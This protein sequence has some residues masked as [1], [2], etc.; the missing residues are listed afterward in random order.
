VIRTF[1]AFD[2]TPGQK[3]ILS[4]AAVALKKASADVRWES[5]DKYHCTLKFLGDTE[6]H[7][8]AAIRSTIRDVCAGCPPMS[9]EFDRLGCFPNVREPRVVWAGCKG[10]YP[11]LSSIKNQID[12]ALA[13]FGFEIDQRTF[14]PHITLGRVKGERGV[15]RLI[16]TL[17]TVT[18]ES[19]TLAV[20]ELLL[21]KSVLHKEGSVYTTLDSFPL[22][23][24]PAA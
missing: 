22:G 18:F 4:E 13:E 11:A 2:T 16:S 1:I 6:E 10:E 17:E 14:H 20:G 24:N 19:F 21:I 15:G 12:R 5:P 9:I 23:G 7:T 3:R 8:L